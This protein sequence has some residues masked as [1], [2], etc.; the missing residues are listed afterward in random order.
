GTATAQLAGQNPAG[1]PVEHALGVV[2]AKTVLAD[3]R[4]AGL[5]AFPAFRQF[6]GQPR[7]QGVTT[8]LV[9]TSGRHQIIATKQSPIRRHT[10][11]VTLIA[12]LM[13]DAHPIGQPCLARCGAPD[14]TAILFL[15]TGLL[16][17]LEVAIEPL[18]AQIEVQIADG[19]A[20]LEYQLY[21]SDILLRQKTDVEVQIDTLGRIG[22]SS[23]KAQQNDEQRQLAEEHW[24]APDKGSVLRRQAPAELDRKRGVQ[25]T[26]GAQHG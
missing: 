2:D 24:A 14:T 3:T 1:R 11:V 7:H 4:P 10:R 9:K 18:I 17:G 25:G 19:A 23:K 5:D 6:E 13:A 22:G 12:A 15:P 21:L 26:E 16:I 20:F 8:R